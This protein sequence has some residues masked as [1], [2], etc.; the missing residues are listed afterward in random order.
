MSRTERP[1]PPFDIPCRS[2]P[3][4]CF[5]PGRIDRK[6]EFPLPDEKT[7]RRIFNIHAS[8]MTVADDVPLD[9][10]ILAKDDLSVADI[11]IWMSRVS[12]TTVVLNLGT[13]SICMVIGKTHKS[14][15][16]GDTVTQKSVLKNTALPL[17]RWGRPPI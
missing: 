1:F 9:D 5:F 11:K 12:S 6:I 7:K 16:N 15:G 10:L 17:L 14:I 2:P 8:R 13:W 4:L 3:S